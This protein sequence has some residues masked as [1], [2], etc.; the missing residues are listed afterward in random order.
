MGQQ[1]NERINT[2]LPELK[3]VKAEPARHPAARDQERTDAGMAGDGT[4]L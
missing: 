1:M 2:L 3:K 4:D